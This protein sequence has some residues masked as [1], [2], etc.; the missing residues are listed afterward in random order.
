MR[1][2][3]WAKKMG[4]REA[5]RSIGV[6]AATLSRMEGGNNVDGKTLAKVLLWLFA[7]CS[8][9]AQTPAP[10]PVQDGIIVTISPQTSPYALPKGDNLYSAVACADTSTRVR[11]ISAGQIRQIAEGAGIAFVDPALLP[12]MITRYVGR[13]IKGRLLTFMKDV[14]S[15]AA[16]AS[17]T[18]AAVKTQLPNVGNAATW[19]YIA[20]G[21]SV[22]AV[23][24]PMAQSKLQSDVQATQATITNGV[25]AALITD[26]A[27]VY[28][29]PVG[30]CSRSV[31]F[32][33]TGADA[34]VRVVLP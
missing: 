26:M 10:Q 32:L 3:R 33:G 2:W 11:A 31:M 5:A 23:L 6:S 18:V 1:E 34:I 16:A 7:A 29:V 30:G 9:M 8:L 19:A 17:G 4:V 12:P 21:S 24:I 27:V 15:P 28:T 20:V 22:I 25:A 14:S 13:S